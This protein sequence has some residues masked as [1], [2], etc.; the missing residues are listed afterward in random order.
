MKDPA[1][2]RASS[3]IP[4]GQWQRLSRHLDEVLDLPE[5]EWAQYLARLC[6]DD[7]LTAAD[8]GRLLH[9]RTH[10][11]FADFLGQSAPLCTGDCA[12]APLVGRQVGQYVI[13]AELGRGGMG[14]V[15]RARRADGRF[16]G[17]VAIK[18]LHLTWLG[19]AGEQRF[20]LEGR[21]LAQLDHP[22]IARLI[23]AGVVDGGQP[24]LVLEHIEGEAI[25][26][27]CN[28]AS[29]DIGARVK[30]FLDATAAVAHAH[31]HLIVHRDLKPSNVLV[32]REGT[33][34][35]LDFGIA[36]LLDAGAESAPTQTLM[37]G[38][39]PQYAAPEQLL[40]HPVTTATD[41]Y[42]LGLMLYVLLTGRHPFESSAPPAASSGAQLVRAVL[43]ETPPRA[44]AAAARIPGRGRALRGDLD[45]ILAKMLEKEP[46]DR[47]G[48]V[49]ALADDLRRYLGNEPV[50]ARPFTAGYRV[51]KFVRRHRVG[52]A[53][54][55]SIAAALIAMTVFASRQTLEARAQRDHALAE[56]QR[57]QAQADLTEFVIGDS[58]SRIPGDTVRM[59]LDRARQFIAIRYRQSPA[60]AAQLLIDVS[61][62]YIDI[63]QDRTA[64]EVIRDVE[65]LSRRLKDPDLTAQLACL[66]AEDLAL[67][68][69]LPT[70]REQLAAGLASLER[71]RIVRPQTGAECADAAALVLQAD[72]DYAQAVSRLSDA[73][74]KLL[75]AGLYGASR[76]TSLTNNLSRALLIEGDFRGAWTLQH[77]LLTLMRAVGR[78]N[79]AAWWPMVRN[80]CRALIGGGQPR[81]AIELVDGALA[82]ARK[83]NSS[84]EPPYF[85]TGC[86]A[87]ARVLAGDAAGADA[88]LLRA[89]RAAAAAGALADST[90]YPALTVIAAIERGD[91][92]AADSRWAALQPQEERGLAAG[93]RGAESVRLIL[94]HARLDV[95]HGRG[96]SALQR[97]QVA[98]RLIAARRQPIT[99]DAYDA[100]ILMAEA[101]LQTGASADAERYAADAIDLARIASIDASSSALLGEALLWRARA[102]GALGET[103]RATATAQESLR[104]LES[105]LL[106]GQPLIAAARALIASNSSTAPKAN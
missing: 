31:R 3:S 81:R 39:T 95:A 49:G 20:L 69:E 36:K 5:P 66:R 99:A 7:P 106:P 57:A 79:T 26:A 37:Q 38:L 67:A 32:T 59:R 64:A 105:N 91:L 54:A 73:R 61:G 65:A 93:G 60:L 97:S 70:A 103:A 51:R 28:R 11:R 46:A 58:L 94:A 87:A 72:G 63:G 24:Y 85:I 104:H 86:G 75:E 76:Y 1:D 16:E 30:L 78:D 40:G 6:R 15:W 53:T 41:V 25:D 2:D 48:S 47:Y 102:E 83:E 21:L 23:D 13:E 52:V 74:R 33:V 18:L 42:A 43:T 101:A 62:R 55:L 90:F 68:R 29:L 96:A 34:K 9:A 10:R 12:P 82:D 4:S 14:S 88:D 17:Y 19:R 80:A 92:A 44:S 77:D 22:N 71:M 35:L 98:S 45:N 50:Q 56:A 100:A 27:Y 84:F 89:T 8:L